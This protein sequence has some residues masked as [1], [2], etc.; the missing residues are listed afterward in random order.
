[1][2]NLHH[3]ELFYYVAKHEG[4]VQACRHI[5]YGVQQPAVSAQIIRLEEELGTS[6]FRRRPFLLTA[7]GRELFDSIAPFFIALPQLEARLRGESIRTLRIVGLSEVM[8]GHAPQMLARLKKRHKGLQITVLE[9]GQKQAEELIL[10][11]DADIAVT[12][13]DP[14]GAGASG[15][16]FKRLLRMPLVLWVPEQSPFRSGAEAITAGAAGR[17]DL[18]SLAPHELLPRLFA[19][20]L[21]KLRREWPVAIEVSSAELIGPYVLSG[22]GVGLSI[23]SPHMPMPRGL[24]ELPLKGFPQLSIG[25]FW[26][27]RPS[28]VA[29]EFLEDLAAVARGTG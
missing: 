25:A 19:T 23:S 14:A 22:L 7:A 24:R 20:G 28:P 26:A 8:R 5:P 12:V 9:A 18:I 3:L 1:M 2:L 4:I 6:L 13:L 10:K 17:L 16:H 11:G 15:L 21:K 29:I 27:G